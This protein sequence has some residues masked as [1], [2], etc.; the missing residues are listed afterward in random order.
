MRY[1]HERKRVSLYEKIDFTRKDRIEMKTVFCL[2]LAVLVLCS[3]ASAQDAW[4]PD[5]KIVMR[6]IDDAT[7][8]EKVVLLW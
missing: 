2:C 1:T 5:P 8:K 6:I 3:V 7:L 4:M